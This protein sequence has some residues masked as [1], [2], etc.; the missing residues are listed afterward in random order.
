[1]PTSR[2]Y[3]LT[4]RACCHDRST[5]W[6]GMDELTIQTSRHWSALITPARA[7][8]SFPQLNI[9]RTTDPDTLE[10]RCG[11]GETR[12]SARHRLCNA[13]RV[14]AFMDATGLQPAP[15][16]STAFPRS[17]GWA[18]FIPHQDHLSAWFDPKRN[19]HLIAD[20]P[21]ISRLG[22]REHAERLEWCNRHN[23]H[24][25]MPE[26]PGMHAP[27][28]GT[29]LFLFSSNSGGLPLQPVLEA[30]NSLPAPVTPSELKVVRL[31]NRTQ[32]RQRAK[33]QLQ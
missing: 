18:Q 28:E 23:Y 11:Q 22:N 7:C 4:L 19:S 32:M 2:K 17:D 12:D 31:I 24:M 25:V 1:M 27:A 16:K 30:L 13:A 29:R 21:Y 14:F 9:I 8:K 5:A 26:W 3:T 20:E 6:H 15:V 33:E 10:V